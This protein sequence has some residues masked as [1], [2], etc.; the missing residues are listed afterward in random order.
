MMFTALGNKAPL[1]WVTQQL[2]EQVIVVKEVVETLRVKDN[3]WNL[4]LSE[5]QLQS[6]NVILAIGA[7]IIWPWY[8]FSAGENRSLWSS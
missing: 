8:S 3:H 1:Q 2:M 7:W 6:K 4:V 5:T